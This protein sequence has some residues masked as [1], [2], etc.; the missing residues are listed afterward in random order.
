[1]SDH[2]QEKITLKVW[3]GNLLDSFVCFFFFIICVRYFNGQ[4]QSNQRSRANRRTGKRINS[5]KDGQ[6]KDREKV[7]CNIAIYLNKKDILG[8][9]C[10][11]VKKNILFAIL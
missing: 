2:P 7:W 9:K 8:T 1:M 6:Q 4:G 11:S 5:Q 10:P 3:V